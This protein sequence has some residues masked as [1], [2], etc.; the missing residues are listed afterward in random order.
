MKEATKNN[1]LYIIIEM[2]SGLRSSDI[3]NLG[4]SSR[5]V[6]E[7]TYQHQLARNIHSKVAPT[8]LPKHLPMRRAG[9]NS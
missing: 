6:Y 5:L 4:E 2:D 8:E 1:D 7:V 3:C 9:G